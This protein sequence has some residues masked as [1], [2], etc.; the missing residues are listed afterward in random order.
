MPDSE[1][2]E[3]EVR[4]LLGGLAHE[5][6]DDLRVPRRMVRRARLRRARTATVLAATGALLGY[7]AFAGAQVLRPAPRPSPR[8][9]I[10]PTTPAPTSLPQSVR[11]LQVHELQPEIMTAA[12]GRFFGVVATGSNSAATILR[13]DPGGTVTRRTLIDPLARYFSH[14][15]AL[16]QALFIGTSVI[17]RFT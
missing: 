7:G 2:V 14:G 6:P 5:V 8:P 10:R 4:Q 15:T 9:A 3:A 1:R 12:G 13:I 11:L 17:R 16:G